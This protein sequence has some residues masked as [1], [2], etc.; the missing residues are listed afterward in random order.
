[1]PEAPND[2]KNITPTTYLKRFSDTTA[3]GQTVKNL[4]ENFLT[5]LSYEG[6]DNT[7]II[8]N[9]ETIIY[10]T[11]INFIVENLCDKISIARLSK[12]CNVS[13]AYLK[14]IFSKYTGLGIHEY[15]LKSKIALAK[16]ML[17]SGNSVTHIAAKLSF[18]SQNYF[19]VAFKRETGV[20]P[21]DYKK[22]NFIK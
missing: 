15:I 9:N 2:I 12:E 1:M 22:Q 4:T 13:S 20:S 18:S 14:K 11:A 3:Y 5:E 6:L 19:S 16:Q 21:S 17:D 8:E 7:H 10:S